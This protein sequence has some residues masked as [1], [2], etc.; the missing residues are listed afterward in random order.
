VVDPE[1]WRAPPADAIVEHV[2]EEARAGAIVD[3]H[4]GW[5]ADA[6]RPAGDGEG[7]RAALAGLRSRGFELVTVSALLDA[8]RSGR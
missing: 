3:L 5:G 8:G 6:E 1:D 4:D 2:R 7:T